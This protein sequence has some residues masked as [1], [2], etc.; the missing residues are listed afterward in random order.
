[1]LALH[2]GQR[3]KNARVVS[4]FK[5]GDRVRLLEGK[6]L[7]DKEKATYSQQIYTVTRQEGYRFAVEGKR[8]LY[9]PSEMQLVRGEV[10]DRVTG[11]AKRQAEA[12]QEQRQVRRVARALATTQQQATRAI[13]AQ[14]PPAAPAHAKKPAVGK[15]G[16]R[17]GKREQ[18]RGETHF[19]VSRF[20]ASKY[21]GGK[22]QFLVKFKGFPKAEWLPAKQLQEDLSADAYRAPRKAMKAT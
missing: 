4:G 7:F 20:E 11:G 16:N 1:M 21:V 8:R 18:V 22:L 14:D 12:A 2:K 10:T 19:D 6:A 3:A 5:P 9:R 13:E 15:R 17:R